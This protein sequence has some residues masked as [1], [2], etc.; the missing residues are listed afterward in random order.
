MD[1]SAEVY[2]QLYSMFTNAADP[3]TGDINAGLYWCFK[4]LIFTAT[5]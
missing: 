3:K 5:S 2:S 1:Q 4:W